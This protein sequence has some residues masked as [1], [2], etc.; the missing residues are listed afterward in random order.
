LKLLKPIRTD[1]EVDLIAFSD[2]GCFSCEPWAIQNDLLYVK[3]KSPIL[4]RAIDVACKH[5]NDNYYSQSPMDPA[6]P[7]YFGQVVSKHA[8]S[9]TCIFGDFK[10]LT[11]G[12]SFINLMHLS[13]S[14]FL[15]AQNKTL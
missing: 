11:P 2:R 15:N 6:G 7:N 3:S 14:G 10:P 4:S 12:L 8:K 1:S 5:V 13:S 9:L